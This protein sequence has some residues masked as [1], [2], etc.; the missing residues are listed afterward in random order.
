MYGAQKIEIET[1][2]V[3]LIASQALGDAIYK[4]SGVKP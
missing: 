3:P 1:K 2:L 4:K